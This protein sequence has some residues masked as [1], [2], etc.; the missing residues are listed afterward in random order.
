[1][2]LS[3]LIATLA[4]GTI[5]MFGLAACGPAAVAETAATPEQS[6]LAA[7]GFDPMDLVAAADDASPSPSTGGQQG[8]HPKLR[9]LRLLRVALRHGMLHGEATVQTKNG[10]ITVAVQRGTVTAIDGKTMTVKSTDGYT[11]TWTFGD[12][13]HVIEHRKAVQPSAISVGTEVGVAGPTDSTT[14]TAR[15]IVVPQAK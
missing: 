10:V 14:T 1:M 12:P 5:G 15:L 7:L 13:I 2:K 4:L 3:K 6:A 9:K 8:D 11:V